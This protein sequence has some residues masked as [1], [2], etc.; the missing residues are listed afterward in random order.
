MP[1][2]GNSI[3]PEKTGKRGVNN[4][5]YQPFYSISEER[6]ISR[7]ERMSLSTGPLLHTLPRQQFCYS[8]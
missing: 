8:V 7:P 4:R 6:Y 2:I 3:E 1:L 5:I